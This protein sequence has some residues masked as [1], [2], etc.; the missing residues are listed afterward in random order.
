MGLAL[1]FVNTKPGLRDGREIENGL[2][3]IFE[4]MDSGYLSFDKLNSLSKVL[5]KNK[6]YP[7][8]LKLYLK[9]SE[10]DSRYLVHISYVYLLSSDR[11]N[12]TIFADRALALNYSQ[13]GNQG[14]RILSEVY[15]VLGDN[16]K[17][18]EALL[19]SAP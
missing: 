12:A 3:L 10:K 16:K 7:E 6:M 11:K 15:K 2:N 9:L 17:R 18:S 19:K 8:M 13:I 1:L 5:E 14:F 4:S